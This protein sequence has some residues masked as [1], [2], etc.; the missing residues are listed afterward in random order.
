M[1]HYF[2]D[3]FTEGA[4]IVK[5][6]KR[7]HAPKIDLI[8]PAISENL[9]EHSLTK[10]LKQEYHNN[11]AVGGSSNEDILNCIYSN[12]NNFES[13]DYIIIGT[14]CPGR[15]K[16]YVQNEEAFNEVLELQMLPTHY[17]EIDKYLKDPST[18]IYDMYNKNTL[19]GINLY[20]K[21]YIMQ[22]KVIDY[23]YSIQKKYIAELQ[24]FL[25]RWNI[26]SIVWEFDLWDWFETLDK[27]SKGAIPDNH[28][29]P[30]SH[31][32]LAHL[33]HECIKDEKKVLTKR[34]V[35]DNIG[36]IF[37]SLEYIPYLEEH[38]N[39]E[40]MK[41]HIINLPVQPNKLPFI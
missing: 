7:L 12:I 37:D 15:K 33:L 5:I 9:L 35:D 41:E 10:L 21:E 32:Q 14:T 8:S 25:S 22:D 2:G 29:S 27:W 38:S 34:Y 19:K 20:Y 1:V 16:F 6:A 26:H 23:E 4:G 17:E 31:L 11:Y 13:H 28:F 40:D 39:S 3:S 24:K 30:N 36:R 18:N